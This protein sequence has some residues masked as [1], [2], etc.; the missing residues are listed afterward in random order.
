MGARTPSLFPPHHNPHQGQDGLGLACRPGRP[1]TMDHGREGRQQ[2]LS[3]RTLWAPGPHQ[4]IT[5]G[6][7]SWASRRHQGPW[8]GLGGD[9]AGR[10][11]PECQHAPPTHHHITGSIL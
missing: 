11:R 4:I 8:V 10:V 2:G 5:G 6:K 1:S 3:A 7:A 9:T